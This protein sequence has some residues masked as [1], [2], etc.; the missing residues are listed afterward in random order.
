MYF[1]SR[2]FFVLFIH[3]ICKGC[4]NLFDEGSAQ[5]ETPLDEGKLMSAEECALHLAKALR[6]RKS[7]CILTGLG[8]AT[9]IAH[10]LFPRL[11]D[12]LTYK[13]IAREANSPF[14]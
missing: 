11:T 2:G 7:E 6:K 13:F 5:G 3:Y 10:R 8:K 4:K 12:K 9:V 1:F 14:K